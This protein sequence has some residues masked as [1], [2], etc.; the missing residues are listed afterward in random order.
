MR[1]SHPDHP[2]GNESDRT[3]KRGQMLNPGCV[4]GNC[5]IGYGMK[6]YSDGAQYIGMFRNGLRHGRGIMTYSNG[7]I[8]SGNF[9]QDLKNGK[10]EY[11]FSGG[12]LFRGLFQGGLPEGPGGYTLGNGHT[13]RGEFRQGVLTGD[14]ISNSGVVRVRCIATGETVLCSTEESSETDEK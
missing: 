10:G 5:T 4:R 9:R 8:Y 3:Q 2:D 14:L 11:S 13:I 6:V 12:T 1:D 7:D